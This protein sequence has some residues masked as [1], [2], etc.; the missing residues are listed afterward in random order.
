MK[1]AFIQ[2]HRRRSSVPP[3]GLGPKQM[4][5]FYP[6]TAAHGMHY[7]VSFSANASIT[8]CNTTEVESRA[9]IQSFNA[10]RK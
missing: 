1:Y 3:S 2:R 9:L 6:E 7:M 4:V 10:I 8:S 5:D